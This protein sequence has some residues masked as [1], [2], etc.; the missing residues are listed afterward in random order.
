MTEAM[1]VQTLKEWDKIFALGI[2]MS[3]NYLII[4]HRIPEF[5]ST[6][7]LNRDK[8]DVSMK[9]CLTFYLLSFILP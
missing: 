3:G 6:D 7:F 9:P 4:R 1:P 8:E 5:A 2:G